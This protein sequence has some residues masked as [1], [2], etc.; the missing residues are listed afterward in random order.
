M[1]KKIDMQADETSGEIKR[2]GYQ[3]SYRKTSKQPAKHGA[4]DRDR[5]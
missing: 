2:L 5:R 3:S 1:G 4:Y